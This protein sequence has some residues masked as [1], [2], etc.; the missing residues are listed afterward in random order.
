[1]TDTPTPIR[2][3]YVGIVDGGHLYQVWRIDTNQLIGWNLTPI[4]PE[5]ELEDR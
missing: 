4:D 2:T 1:M 5:P 3:D